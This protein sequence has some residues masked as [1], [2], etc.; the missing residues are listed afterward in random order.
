MGPRGKVEPEF[1]GV[2]AQA[3]E[4]MAVPFPYREKPGDKRVLQRT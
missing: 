3:V 2:W 1:S 4:Q